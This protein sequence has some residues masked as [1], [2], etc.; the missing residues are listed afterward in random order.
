MTD[1]SGDNLWDSREAYFEWLNENVASFECARC[2]AICNGDRI[3]TR[4]GPVDV[5][6]AL[7]WQKSGKLQ[8]RTLSDFVT[9]GTG[10]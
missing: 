9:G 8:Q 1:H 4:F 10:E 2:G 5:G 3:D 7:L 6:C